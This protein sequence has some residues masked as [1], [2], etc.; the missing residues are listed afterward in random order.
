MDKTADTK[1]PVHELI[2]R[3]WSPRAFDP[4]PVPADQIRSMLE[5]A[6]W[7]ASSFNEQP[8]SF[9]V[10]R[11]EDTAAFDTMLGCLAPGNQQWAKNAGMLILTVAR[12][13]FTHNDKPNRVAVHDIGL[14]AANLTFQAEQFGLRVHQMAGIDVAKI[15]ETYGVPDGYDPVTA[16]AVGHAGTLD[17]LPDELHASESA[18]RKRKP[19]CE[20]VFG[21][22]WGKPASW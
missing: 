22:A 12:S 7:S 5:A 13:A 21:G 8:W 2:A 3:R 18:P 17:D 20:F 1:F 16:I 14:A 15:C 9:L 19:Q 10:A 6:R 4:R 11:R